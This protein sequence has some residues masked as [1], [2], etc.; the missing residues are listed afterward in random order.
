MKAIVW[1]GETAAV[2]EGVEV[3]TPRA[4]EVATGN[5]RCS[6]SS[7]PHSPRFR[8]CDLGACVARPTDGSLTRRTDFR[9]SATY[10]SG[11]SALNRRQGLIFDTYT[12]NVR[13]RYALT[14][15]LALYTEYLYYFYDFTGNLQLAPGIPAG[16]E[17][18]GLRAGVTLWMP[19]LRK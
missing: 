12:G 1:D 16:L 19:L 17:R 4:T 18:H 10:A 5:S 14:R 15:S 7:R 9:A 13:L 8:F 6:G 11:E 3:R 2:T